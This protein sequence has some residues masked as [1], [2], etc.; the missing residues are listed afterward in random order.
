[1]TEVSFGACKLLTDA[2]PDQLPVGIELVSIT[3]LTSAGAYSDFMLRNLGDYIATSHC[4]VIQW[5][6]HVIDASRWMPE[7]LAY[8]Y[9]GASWPQFSDGQDV[10]NGGF[11]LRSRRLIQACRKN[12]FQHSHPED[13]AI[14]RR[15]RAW[16][17]SQG[18]RFAPRALADHFSAERAGDPRNSFGYHG[19]WH[20]PRVLGREQFWRIYRDLDERSTVRHDFGA[21]LQE[22]LRGR[23]GATRALGLISD[24]LRDTIG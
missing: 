23:G 10:G 1:M 4:L 15:N 6:G 5:D 8:D 22:L 11:S 16:L 2:H 17:E 3:P 24:R 20:M 18:M 7:F 9:V 14:G 21:L 13:V 12:G 19:V